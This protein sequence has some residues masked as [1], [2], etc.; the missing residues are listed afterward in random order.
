MRLAVSPRTRADQ[1]IRAR[2]PDLPKAANDYRRIG[3][4][5]AVKIRRHGGRSTAAAGGGLAETLS[6]AA[7]VA[8]IQ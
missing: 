2:L 7:L 8:L 1:R 3:Q 5:V 4:T 6:P